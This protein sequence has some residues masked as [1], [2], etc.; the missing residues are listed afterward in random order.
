[1]AERHRAEVVVLAIP[2]ADSELVRRVV[3]EGEAAG[4]DV[5]VLPPLWEL[6][7]S[8]VGARATSAP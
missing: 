3:A 7:K 1:M 4:L 6:A 8:D 5:R 2:S